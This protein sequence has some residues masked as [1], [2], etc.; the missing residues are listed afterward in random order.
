MPPSARCQQLNLRRLTILDILTCLR[1]ARHFV[2]RAT[3]VPLPTFAPAL[4]CRCG[5][6]RLAVR[7]ASF[8]IKRYCALLFS[9]AP[10][11]ERPI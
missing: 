5:T 8:T 1:G 9:I 3:P 4:A 7:S 6:L 10:S 11:G 2:L